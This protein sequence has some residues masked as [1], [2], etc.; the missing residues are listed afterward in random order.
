M[1]RTALALLALVL[2]AAP[3]AA[4]A[5]LSSLDQIVDELQQDQ[6]FVDPDADVPL[7]EGD[8][9]DV[10]AGS[11][12]QVYVVALPEAASE[13]AGGDA[14]VVDAIGEA[15]ADD[16]A[17][18]LLLTDAPSV[19]ADNSQALGARGVNAGVAVRS[20]E[21]GDFDEA[22]VRDFLQQ[23]V[24]TIDAQATGGTV[25]DGAIGGG[26][27]GGDG[28]GSPSGFAPLLVLGGL[29]AGA[30]ALVRR[31]RSK[32]HAKG[33][34]DARADVESLYGRLGSD[35][36]LLSPGD[37]AIAR[38]ALADAAERYNATGALMSKA[39][40]LGEFAAAR[41]TAVEGLAAARVVRQRLGLDPGPEVPLPP[42]SGPALQERTVVQVGEQEHEGSPE[43]EPGR[44]H[45]YEGGYYGSQHVPGGWYATPFW[46]TLL[47]SSV[48]NGGYGGHSGGMFGG[49][50]SGGVG[51]GRRG[52]LGGGFGGGGRRGGGGGF[53]GFGGGGGWSGGGG[54]RSGGGG[55]KW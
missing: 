43:Y 3:A 16:S 20:I 33:L 26:G 30:Y 52:G 29:G 15:L 8:A 22:G 1:R 35:V 46:Q 51:G 37:D 19:Y 9:R 17:V 6:V 24:S 40:T 34:E 7:D 38:Q 27:S 25:D 54:G 42:G 49:G 28:G 14:A 48:L 39:D 11:Q 4:Q 44:P 55:G 32:A 5:T 10:V 23:F 31:G 41:R 47:L 2:L 13:R 21:R 12:V 45:Y 36:Q 50:I 18:V 53:G